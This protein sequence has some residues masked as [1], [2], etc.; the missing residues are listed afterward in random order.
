MPIRRLKLS[1]GDSA[2]LVAVWVK[3][4]ELAVL[5]LEQVYARLDAHT[6]RYQSFASGYE[7]VLTV[8]GDGLVTR[9]ANVWERL[10][11]KLF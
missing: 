10:R 9:Y 1:P 5:P 4:P 2:R 7:A 3:F 6:Y 11:R 8:D